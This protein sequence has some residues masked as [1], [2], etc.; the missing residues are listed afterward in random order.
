MVFEDT[1]LDSRGNPNF[2][3]IFSN[4]KDSPNQNIISQDWLKQRTFYESILV[5]TNSCQ[6]EHF[7]KPEE[8]SPNYSN[9]TF[10]NLILSMIRVRILSPT[11]NLKQMTQNKYLY[12]AVLT[13]SII[14]TLGIIFSSSNQPL[15]RDSFNL[16]KPELLA[17]LARIQKSPDKK[18]LSSFWYAITEILT[19][20]REILQRRA[21]AFNPLRLSLVVLYKKGWSCLNS[22]FWLG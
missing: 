5:F 14:K 11:N 1:H 4:D 12:H 7:S 22:W 19:K 21:H 15:V 16:A 18:P 2:S 8:D 13:I 10:T 9:C 20:V 3:K 17:Y 6:I